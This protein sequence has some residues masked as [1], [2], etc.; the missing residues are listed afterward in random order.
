MKRQKSP[1]LKVFVFR[2][3]QT[4]GYQTTIQKQYGCCFQMLNDINIHKHKPQ[5]TL[6][7]AVTGFNIILEQIYNI[8]FP[9]LPENDF[10]FVWNTRCCTSFKTPHSPPESPMVQSWS[11]PSRV[12]PLSMPALCPGSHHSPG[13]EILLSQDTGSEA[14]YVQNNNKKK[15]VQAFL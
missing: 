7:E 3:I 6:L 9:A 13:S 10:S 4:E 14:L 1:T 2:L 15:K 5:H 11:E 8:F 12:P